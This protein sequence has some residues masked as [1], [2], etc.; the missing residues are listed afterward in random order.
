[1]A[2]AKAIPEGCEGIIPHLIVEGGSK[3]VEF[4][5]KAFGAEEVMRM[6]APDG[7]LM[8]AELRIGGSLV[9][10]C[11][12]FPEMCGGQARNPKALGGTPGNIHRYVPDVDAVV[13]RAADA[14]ATVKMPPTDMFWGDRYGV[15]ED[16]FGH[17]WAFATHQKDLTPE[18]MGRA[19]A[20]AFASAPG[21]KPAPSGKKPRK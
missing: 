16:P 14:G 11:D 5:K 8:H 1:M 13:R 10:L 15:V 4:Y 17:Q 12:D 2:K 20:Q 18:E 7:R 9:F 21:E 3:A 6:P 19:Q